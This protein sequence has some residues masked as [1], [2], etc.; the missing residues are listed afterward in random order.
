VEFSAPPDAPD[1]QFV[2]LFEATDSGAP[3]PAEWTVK[4]NHG[5]LDVHLS[6]RVSWN[7]GRQLV[8]TLLDDV[9]DLESARLLIDGKA[10]FHASRADGSIVE[11]TWT[12]KATLCTS[13]FPLD[14]WVKVEWTARDGTVR[15]EKAP[16]PLEELVLERLRSNARKVLAFLRA[17]GR[18]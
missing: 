15:C 13:V 8:A 1:E 10:V 6:K 5:L 7:G 2:A 18:T 16:L 17:C 9:D 4:E 12:A 3:L 14:A 11:T